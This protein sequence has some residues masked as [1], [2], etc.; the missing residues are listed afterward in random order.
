MGAFLFDELTEAYISRQSLDIGF[1]RG[2][3]VPF[4]KA[5]AAPEAAEG[6]ATGE[7][8]A[9]GGLPQG[10]AASEM[11][12][13]VAEALGIAPGFPY[14]AAYAEFLKRLLGDGAVAYLTGIAGAEAEAGELERACAH[15]RAAL[16][17]APDDLAAMYGYA[18]A[19]R[20]M[21]LR[22][23]NADYVGSFK[24]E[25]NEFFELLALRHEEFPE[26]HYYLGYAYLN[27]GLYQKAHLS[28]KRFLKL[29]GGEGRVGPEGTAAEASEGGEPAARRLAKERE[30]VTERLRQLTVPIEIERG[31]NAVLSGRLEEGAAAL[32]P[33]LAGKYEDWWPLRY[34]LGMAYKGLGRDEDAVGMF[35]GVLRRKPSHVGAMEEL[36]ALYDGLGDAAMSGK[37]RQKAA[38]VGGRVSMEASDEREETVNGQ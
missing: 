10:V 19:C 20:D 29:S 27:L 33:H 11:A 1:M 22:G 34:Y 14:A 26:A 38:L 5:G 8:A 16:C 25:S 31:C 17:L 30:E 7:G 35:K 37:Y 36:A 2:V 23:G 4:R 9:P 6:G 12:M 28:W 3:P 13:N 24:A 21:Y 15:F 32:E 18:R